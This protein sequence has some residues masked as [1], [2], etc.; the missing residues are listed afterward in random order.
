M[1]RFTPLCLS[2]GLALAACAPAAEEIQDEDASRA[3]EEPVDEGAVRQGIDE[4]NR[5]A[6]QS[7]AA[8]DVAGFVAQTYTED[9]MI[10][11]PG[12]PIISGHGGIEEFWSSAGEQ[13]GLTGVRLETQEL[14]TLGP[15]AAYEIGLGTLETAQGPHEAKYVVIWKRGE[16][17]RWR[18]HVDIWNDMPAE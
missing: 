6:E 16:D 15:D 7:I 10:L 1:R 4:T 17:G 18:W 11:P 13:L 9:A 5:A 2:L 8:G 3:T 14:V 12:G